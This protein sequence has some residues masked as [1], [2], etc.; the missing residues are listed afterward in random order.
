MSSEPTQRGLLTCPTCHQAA[1]V[2][3]DTLT[4]DLEA[5][6]GVVV[7]EQVYSCQ[8]PG[9]DETVKIDHVCRGPFGKKSLR[10]GI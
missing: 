9:C 3:T 5:T 7:R 2:R 4:N 6:A 10:Q 1:M 8:T